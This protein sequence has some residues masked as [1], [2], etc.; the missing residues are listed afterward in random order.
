MSEVDTLIEGVER[1]RNR[2]LGSVSSLSGAQAAFRP[3]ESEWSV[4][5]VLEHLYLAEV[6]GVSKMGC[7]GRSSSGSGLD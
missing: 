2:L 4:I 1:S 6:S 5:D 7:V 3:G